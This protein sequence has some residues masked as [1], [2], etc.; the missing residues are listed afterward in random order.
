MDGNRL[1]TVAGFAAALAVLAGLVWLVGIGETLDA[2]TTADPG[3]LLA[4]AGIAML[5]LVSWGLALWTVLQA[6]GAPVAPH[7]AVLVFVAA[8]FSNNVTPFGQAGGEP[9]SALLI[10]TAAD[11]EYETGL[12]AIATVDTVHFLPSV[13][14]AIVGF[15]FVAAGA[16]QLTR[17]LAFAAGAVAVLAVGIPI[18][19]VLG[20]R[21]RYRV[22][23]AITRGVAPALATLSDIVPRWSPPSAANIEGRIEGF[24]SAIERIATDRRTVL[25]TFGLSAFGWACLS[26]SLWTSLYAVGTPVPVEVVLLVVPVASIASVVPLPGGSGAIETVLVTLLVSTAT[27]SAALATSAVLIHRVGSYLLPTVIGGGV[28]TAL[29]VDRAASPEE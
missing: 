15:T 2:L 11:T 12:A 5:W 10:S 9:L 6:L 24:F 16:V 4:V 26:A 13:G 22:Q 7:T 20:W 17:N 8:V 14:Y 23:A 28:A 19:A 21:H 18:A 27:V 3:A 29:G 1:A 25:Q